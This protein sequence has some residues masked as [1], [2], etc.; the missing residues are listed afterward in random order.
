MQCAYM[1]KFWKGKE[2]RLLL[3]ISHGISYESDTHSPEPSPH[4]RWPVSIRKTKMISTGT[5]RKWEDVDY[6][7]DDD[8]P[9]FGK[10]T[11]PV[12]NLPMDFDREPGDGLEYLFMVR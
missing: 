1:I 5:K 12:A 9:S 10:Q 2:K 3:C 7:S 11:L 6:D 8:E 4:C